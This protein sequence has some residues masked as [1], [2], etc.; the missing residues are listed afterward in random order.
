MDVDNILTDIKKGQ[1]V[2]PPCYLLYGEE[3]YLVKDALN[4]IIAILLPTSDRDLNLFF[5]DGEYEDIDTLC[6]MILTPPLIPGRKIIVLRN[7][8]LFQSKRVLPEIIQQIRS[9]FEK[10]PDRAVGYFMQFLKITGW[11]LDDLKDDKWRKITDDDWQKIAEGDSSHDRGIW[12]PRIM[13]VCISRGVDMSQIKD[14]TERLEDIL[15]SGIPEGN[16]LII[17][18]ETVD[19]RKRIFRIISEIGV[20]LH[21]S[22]MKGEVRQKNA[23]MDAAEDLLAKT[24]KKLTPK[25]WA[26]IGKKTDFNLAD[27][28]GAIEKLIAYTGERMLI[29]DSDVEEVVGKTKEDAVFDLIRTLVD[30]DLNMAL[31]NLKDLFYQGVNHLLILSM[32]SREIR[33]IFHAKTFIRSGKLSSFHANLDYDVFQKSCYPFIR[34]QTGDAGKKSDRGD[35]I[36]QHPYVI[37][38][39]LKNSYRFSYEQ[40]IKQ[41]DDLVDMDIAFKTTSRDPKVMLQR[42]IIDVCT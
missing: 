27:S 35:L 22:R 36:S 3:E 23:L 14:D 31:L 38:S 34:E 19:K 18:A 5:M 15:K 29:D 24:G 7:T 8:R 6:E 28:M 40:L 32:I 1:K 17:T 39:A 41:L 21:F 20:V 13:E 12:L 33:F 9:H 25:A 37:Y 42:F 26:A 30:K 10:H 16:H 4:R 2:P 11:S